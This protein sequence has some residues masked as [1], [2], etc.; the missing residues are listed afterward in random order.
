LLGDR[1]D[2]WVMGQIGEYEGKRFKDAAR[3]DLELGTLAGAGD[4]L[5]VEE[6]LKEHKGLLKR[7]KDALGERVLEVRISRRLADSP[8]CLVLGEHDLG[9]RMRRILAGSGQA[10]PETKPV[11][12]LNVDHALVKHLDAL[13]DAQRFSE[14]ALV[15]FDQAALAEGGQLANPAQ[16]VRRLNRLLT[17]LAATPPAA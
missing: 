8:A 17:E 9:S 14:L 13:R 16:Y 3:G 6:S 4:E 2:E 7:V 12:E 5:K 10:P 1:I 11:L 15:L